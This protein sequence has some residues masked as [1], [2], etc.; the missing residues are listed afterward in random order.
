MAATPPLRALI[1]DT[2]ASADQPE[3]LPAYP[4]APESVAPD[5]MI[6][7]ARRPGTTGRRAGR[8]GVRWRSRS[9]EQPSYAIFSAVPDDGQMAGSLLLDH[10]ARRRAMGR[11]GA[12]AQPGYGVQ[13]GTVQFRG[14]LLDN[15]EKAPAEVV[16]STADR[17]G[18]STSARRNP[19]LGS[20]TSSSGRHSEQPARSGCHIM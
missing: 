9:D 4:A 17:L 13:L 14:R 1:A 2:G 16:T 7:G 18:R 20:L 19:T 5:H 3:S 6:H 10:A 15:P 11:R 8:G 12:R